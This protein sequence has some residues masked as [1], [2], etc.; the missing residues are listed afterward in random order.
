MAKRG[1]P[2]HWQA[3]DGEDHRDHIGP[4]LDLGMETIGI[5]GIDYDSMDMKVGIDVAK[6]CVLAMM[7]AAF[8]R[9]DPRGA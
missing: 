7:L 1:R 6:L 8:F 3:E 9:K 5:R 4:I 2:K